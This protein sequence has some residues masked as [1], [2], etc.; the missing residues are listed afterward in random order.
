MSCVSQHLQ[1][2]LHQRSL[3]AGHPLQGRRLWVQLRCTERHAKE[4]VSEKERCRCARVGD[5][6]VHVSGKGCS[7]R[8]STALVS[9]AKYF[10]KGA[11]Q[12]SS[13]LQ[14]SAERCSPTLQMLGPRQSEKS[15]ALSP[16][17]LPQVQVSP[18]RNCCAQPC[19]CEGLQEVRG[20]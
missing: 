15:D 12:L 19:S 20:L 16:A 14:S 9:R 8:H 4:E 2:V 3:L 10:N 7:L 6:G 18:V 17:V 13:A 11:L 1:L 5:C